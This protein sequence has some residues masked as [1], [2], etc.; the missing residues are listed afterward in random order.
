MTPLTGWGR[1]A[2]TWA[3][4]AQPTDAAVLAAEG[5]VYLAKD[6]RISPAALTG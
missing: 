5:R 4:V 2:P 3:R 1:I 6:F